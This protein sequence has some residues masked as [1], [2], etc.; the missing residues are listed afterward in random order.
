[1]GEHS[2]HSLVCECLQL[3][4][5]NGTLP[6]LEK[7][8][9]L[10]SREIHEPTNEEVEL[11][12]D[13]FLLADCIPGLEL[14]RQQPYLRGKA[15]EYI[16]EIATKHRLNGLRQY[17]QLIQPG[18]F[19][20]VDTMQKLMC[21]AISNANLPAVRCVHQILGNLELRDDTYTKLA[22]GNVDLPGSILEFLVEQRY[23]IT[24]QTAL[25]ASRARN[26]V[27]LEIL[28]KILQPVIGI[29]LDHC[30][31]VSVIWWI[32]RNFDFSVLDAGPLSVAVGCVDDVELFELL[33]KNNKLDPADLIQGACAGESATVVSRL[34]RSG[35]RPDERDLLCAMLFKRPGIFCDLLR[36]APLHD[37]SE[38]SC[39]HIESYATQLGLLLPNKPSVNL[40][41]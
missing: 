3:L 7:F 28:K 13:L 15:T 11:M 35:Y 24:W 22:A 41:K 25:A 26:F 34:L 17:L 21:S 1:M 30:P 29:M 10:T 32:V 27:A 19:S 39:A 38:Y 37:F 20:Y 5:Q 36:H 12:I 4:R 18:Q 31:H 23:A 9:K 2:F 6:S 16:C 14:C 33:R 8:E 40:D